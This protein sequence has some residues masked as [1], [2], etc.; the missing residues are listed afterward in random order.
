MKRVK[1]YII[2]TNMNESYGT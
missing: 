2:V 1:Y